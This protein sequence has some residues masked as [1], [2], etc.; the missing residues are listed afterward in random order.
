[1]FLKATRKTVRGKTYTNHLLVESI[2]TP[3]GPRHRT[4]CSLGSL[5]P[6]PRPYWLGLAHKLEAALSG[7]QS[8]LPNAELDSLRQR[9]E[10]QPPSHSSAEPVSVILEQIEVTEARQAGS[11][12]VGHQMWRRLQLDAI[13]RKAGLNQRARLLTE[14]MT[15]NRLVAP[16]SEHAMP[17]WVRRTALADLLHADFRRLNDEALY[18]NLDRLHPQRALIEGELAAR[19]KELFALPESIYLYDLTSTY[20]EGQALSN[21]KAKRGY[22]RDQRPDCKQVVVGLVLDGDGFP[23]AHEVFDG[24]RNDSTTVD[25]MLAALEKRVGKKAGATVTVDRGMAYDKNIEQIRGRGYHY[26]V[27]ARP[28]ERWEHEQA[29]VEESDWEEIVRPPSPTNPGQKKTQV[30][31]KQCLAGEE[32]HVL[33]L[34]EQRK[35]KDRAIRELQEK[36]LLA[37]L[38]SMSRGMAKRKKKPR[39]EAEMNQA[40]GRLRERYSRVG[41]YY[42]IRYEAERR[43]LIWA[44]DGEWKHRAERLDG[45]YVLK[46]DRRDMSKEEIWRQYIL[47]T[48]V[49][50]A[51]RAMKSPLLERPIFH[52]LAD[53]VEA[54]IFLCVLA[55]HLLATV[56]KTFLDQGVHTSWASLREQLATHQ[57]V[58]VVLPTSDGQQICIRKATTPEPEHKQIYQ[59]LR[60]SDEILDPAQSRPIVTERSCK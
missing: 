3:D 18:R 48:R 10:A 52:Q 34:S 5:E 36:R 43:A 60:I 1:M 25:D 22:S 38:E 29:F 8:L 23:K 54:H 56:E 14:V 30:R 42:Q 33:C 39:T 15:I 50:S 53:R 32:V 19:E 57:V 13:L 7:Q 58:T 49:E 16:S 59:V 24:N 35:E 4:I 40:I 20:F 21:E 31:L 27:A 11:V 12:Y 26:L 55:Y 2:S 9:I 44:V 47:L 41:R 17:D 37:N 46:T 51:F 45:S 28:E 6:A